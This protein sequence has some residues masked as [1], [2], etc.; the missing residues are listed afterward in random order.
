M[1][2][3]RRYAGQ[4]IYELAAKR[5]LKAVAYFITAGL[6]FILPVSLIR[7][8]E[9]FLQN[10]TSLNPDQAQASLDVHPI[11]YVFFIVPALGLIVN[12]MFWWKR[13]NHASQGAKG[14]EDTA[15]GTGLLRGDA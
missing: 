11:F 12:G 8:I 13:A 5:R 4:N 6:V 2:K 9:N 7:T 3:K 10:L 1:S 14:E 15:Q